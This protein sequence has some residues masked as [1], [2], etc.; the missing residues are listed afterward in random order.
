MT[1]DFEFFTS[2]CKR[3]RFYRDNEAPGVIGD[4]LFYLYKSE[5]ESRKHYDVLLEPT[6]VYDFHSPSLVRCYGAYFKCGTSVEPLK[7]ALKTDLPE[8]FAQFYE[9]FGESVVFTR[10]TPLW[11]RPLQWM[12]EGFE[13]SLDIDVSEGRFFPFASL[14]DSLHL[15]LR[16]SDAGDKWQVIPSFGL[17]Y[18]EITRQVG[19]AR[20]LTFY[21]WLKHV[22]ETDGDDDMFPE[23]PTLTVTDE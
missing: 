19:E 7:T 3:V 6:D 10:K 23:T 9:Q 15:G 5:A 16:K 1:Y 17:L 18:S 22:I 12:I 8:D 11:I 13:D 4:P 2:H 14:E 20:N 21:E